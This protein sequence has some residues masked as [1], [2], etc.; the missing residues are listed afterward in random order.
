MVAS[1]E[2]IISIQAEISKR[3][4]IDLPLQ[5]SKTKDQQGN[6]NQHSNKKR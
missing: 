2:K 1:I 6:I 5:Q 4:Y 3:F